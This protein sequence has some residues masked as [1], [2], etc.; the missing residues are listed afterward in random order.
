MPSLT[1][2]PASKPA[3]MDARKKTEKETVPPEG[4]APPFFP[5]FFLFSAGGLAAGF[6]AREE[7]NR[8]QDRRRYKEKKK[9]R[10]YL[11]LQE[12]SRGYECLRRA[13]NPLGLLEVFEVLDVFDG[14]FATIRG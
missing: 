12:L 5:S 9:R 7:K 4:P 13:T 14:K 10:S 11:E 6:P 8:R 1:V 2:N 3:L